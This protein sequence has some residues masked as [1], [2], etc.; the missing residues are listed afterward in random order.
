MVRPSTVEYRRLVPKPR[1]GTRTIERSSLTKSA[2]KIQTNRLLFPDQ[3]S[4]YLHVRNSI[5]G[6]TIVY[7]M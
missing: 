7:G 3:L 4:F 2:G 6:G 5:C 1:P